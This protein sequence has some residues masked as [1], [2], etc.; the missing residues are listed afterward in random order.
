VALACA[1]ARI[2]V[3]RHLWKEEVDE[4]GKEFGQKFFE[5]VVMVSH[6]E[7]E[8]GRTRVQFKSIV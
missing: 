1:V 7:I 3:S 2:E 5:E 4:F 6:S 8:V